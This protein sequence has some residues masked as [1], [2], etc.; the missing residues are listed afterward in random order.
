MISPLLLWNE[1]RV[2][3]I[4][5]VPVPD[6]PELLVCAGQLLCAEG[7]MHR[8]I[9]AVLRFPGSGMGLSIK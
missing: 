5:E 7:M 8:M 2:C 9:Q 4:S 3:R 6:S 1:F